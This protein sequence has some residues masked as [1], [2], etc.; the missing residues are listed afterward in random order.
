MRGAKHRRIAICVSAAAANESMRREN[1]AGE[2]RAN[3]ARRAVIC[4]REFF[5]FR[6]L[7]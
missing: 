2:M 1:S 6:K 4:K 7:I 5:T 3:G